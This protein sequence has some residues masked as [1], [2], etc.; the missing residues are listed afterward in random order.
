[1]IYSDEHEYVF[2]AIPKTG[3]TTVYNWLHKEYGAKIRK[4]KTIPELEDRDDGKHEPFVPKEYEH[5]YIF[6]SVRCPY[7]RA[8]SE[9]LFH[10]TFDPAAEY[11]IK[12]RTLSF[13]DYVEWAVENGWMFTQTYF[14]SHAPR[15]DRFLHLEKLQRDS[16][17]LPFIKASPVLGHAK[18]GSYSE[19]WQDYV[20][21]QAERFITSWASVDFV[22]LGYDK[23]VEATK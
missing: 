11:V 7:T 23:S 19:R 1:M 10:K 17:Y 14:L 2:L 20:T 22:M 3:S 21:D 13:Q 8:V 4:G 6:T 5:Y 16:V 18:K 9:Y 15:V 12:A